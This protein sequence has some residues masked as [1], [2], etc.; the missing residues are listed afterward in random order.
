MAASA[1]SAALAPGCGAE[2]E[3]DVFFSQTL[4]SVI[5]CGFLERGIR[6]REHSMC[7]LC[8][9]LLGEGA[10]EHP[11]PLLHPGE[12]LVRL[13][14][15]RVDGVQV[16][17][18]PVQLLPL[19]VQHGQGVLTRVLGLCVGGLLSNCCDTTTIVTSSSMLS[20]FRVEASELSVVAFALAWYLSRSL[21]SAILSSKV[22]DSLNLYC[23]HS[24]DSK[25]TL[26]SLFS[27]ILKEQACGFNSHEKL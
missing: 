16:A 4:S 3:L 10:R 12:M 8:R 1:E 17:L 5:S 2:P 25:M 22:N 11:A 21:I 6:G 13:L 24:P 7:R 14:H 19:L 23:K 15:L 20:M 18:H 26:C 9:Y 27:V